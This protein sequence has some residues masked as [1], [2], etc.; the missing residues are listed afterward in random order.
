MAD[1]NSWQTDSL[2]IH[3]IRIH[4]YRT[5]GELPT[6]VLSH[7]AMD[8][9]LCWTRLAQALEA[10]Y[11]LIMPDARGHGRSDPGAGDYTPKARAADLIGLIEGLGL[12]SPVIGGHSMGAVTSIYAAG[13]RPDLISGLFMED[14]S[15]ALPGEP[16]I[17]RRSAETLEQIGKM[18]SRETKLSK[19][20]PGFML[21]GFLKRVIPEFPE[22]EI[23]PWLKSKKLISDDLIEAMKAP[24]WLLGEFDFD[25]LEKVRSP[26]M[27]IYGDR[28]AGAL[29]SEG[30]AF[31][32]Q[33][34]IPGLRI[35]HFPGANHDIRRVRFEGYIRELKSFLAD[36]FRNQGGGV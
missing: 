11:D 9:G 35:V 25:L 15:L 21:R 28:S 8:D 33:K 10:D 7:G 4:Y 32:F 29:L 36:V 26:A 27:L 31:E 34:R 13:L 16:V 17:K 5:G 24:A 6:V 1:H 3:G 30:A 18:I 14:P 20:A 23:G 19:Q 2:N 12:E 22:E